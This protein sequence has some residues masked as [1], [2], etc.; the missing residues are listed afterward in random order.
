VI[1]NDT[2]APAVI[3]V[4]TTG[5]SITIGIY[6]HT[7]DRTVSSQ[8]GERMPRSY[9]PGFSIEVRRTVR[10]DGAVLSTKTLRW[11]YT[12]LD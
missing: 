4:R 5:T 12:G 3:R 2:G 8:T 6:G 1:R 11:S 9:G 10:Q 7:G